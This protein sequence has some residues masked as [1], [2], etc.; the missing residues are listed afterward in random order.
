ML[1]S[2]RARMA[3]AGESVDCARLHVFG[4]DGWRDTAATLPALRVGEVVLHREDFAPDEDDMDGESPDASPEAWGAASGIAY[5]RIHE[6][7][8]EGQGRPKT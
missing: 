2:G 8:P 1:L 3:V 7:G 5:D 4:A 6:S